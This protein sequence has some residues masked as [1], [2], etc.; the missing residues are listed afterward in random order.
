MSSRTGFRPE[1]VTVA[2]GVDCE[3]IFRAGVAPKDTYRD[4]QMDV[5]GPGFTIST[6]T[7]GNGDMV[8]TFSGRFT[9]TP[10]QA[11]KG[12]AIDGV[13]PLRII[14]WRRVFGDPARRYVGMPIPKRGEGLPVFDQISITNDAGV[15]IA[16]AFFGGDLFASVLVDGSFVLLKTNT[17]TSTPNQYLAL[18][19][20]DIAGGFKPGDHITFKIAGSY[21]IQA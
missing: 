3:Q 13:L 5:P 14:P 19:V 9:L 10:D 6:A 11:G 1:L 16:P 17:A 15:S 4:Y 18:T 21:E 8:S 20:A 7:A 12:P 2:T